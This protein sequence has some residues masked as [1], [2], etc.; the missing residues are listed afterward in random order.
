MPSWG[1]TLL[2]L[3][4]ALALP[5]CTTIGAHDLETL[6]K[7]DFGPRESLR[8]CLLLDDSVP[9]PTARALMNEVAREFGRYAI[10][11]QVTR[12]QAW[13]R[14]GFTV[15]EII[16]DV[17]IRPLEAPCDR[18]VAM[19]GRNLGDALW[20]LAMPE[21]L[22]AVET[23]THS[24]GYVVARTASLNQAFSTPGATAVHESYHFL[25]C[26]HGLVMTECYRR[27]Q[28]IKLAARRNRSL[29][30]DF[31][32][33]LGPQGRPIETREMVDATLRAAI[34]G[35]TVPAE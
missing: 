29:G 28:A 21:V 15:K 32:P 1:R 25:G 35:A 13:T 3:L 6:N 31:F 20:G 8:F 11:V 10:D 34:A 23:L 33:A 14:P 22:G 27:I 5:A 12:T 24:K 17:A 9:E 2:F 18:L 7:T 4:A 16:A 19:V 30:R 26:D